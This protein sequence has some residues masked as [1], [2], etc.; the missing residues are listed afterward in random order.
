MD[1][2]DCSVVNL[3]VGWVVECIDEVGEFV[4]SVCPNHK[5]VVQKDCHLCTFLFSYWNF[6]NC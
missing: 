3:M 6:I 1:F 2:L 5:N 4:L